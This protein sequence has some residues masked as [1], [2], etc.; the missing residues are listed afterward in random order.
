MA[1][2]VIDG[3]NPLKGLVRLGGAKNASYKLMIASL[4]GQSQSRLLNFSHIE[5]VAITREIIES[6]GGKTCT[7][8]ERTVFIDPSKLD[9]FEI[10]QK[11]GPKSR[12]STMFIPP[13]LHRLGRAVV[14]TPGGDNIGQ[15]PLDRHFD[16]LVAMG[17][18]ISQTSN[19]IEAMVAGRLRGVEYKFSK[20]SHTGT[21]TLIM[22]AVLAE[23]RTV[24]KN[25]GLES[26]IDDLIEM[27]NDMGARIRRRPGRVIEIHGVDRLEGTIHKIIPDRNE[28][29]SYA[30]AALI[31]KGDIIVENANPE[32]LEAFLEKLEEVG[33][34]Y[35]I[36]NYGI[37]FFY[38][39]GMIAT[40]VVTRPHPG[41]MTDWQPL[42]T[43]LATQLQ[44]ESLIHETI[45]PNRFQHV[46]GLKKFGAKINYAKVDV[47]EPD[48]TYNFNYQQEAHD[49]HAVVVSGQT[50]L[51]PASLDVYDL[52]S[53]AT[54]VLAALAANGQSHLS[55]V[56]LI[57][58]GYESFDQRLRS[59][60]AKIKRLD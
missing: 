23:G 10:D 55:K 28:A 33:A 59:M 51:K 12:A 57:D 21:E 25:A 38:Q 9:K 8:G 39:P 15:R 37:R 50:L 6:L 22:A 3:G 26:E 7:A 27:L 24:L 1:K 43:V 47:E 48:K 60:G 32:H 17:A 35:E 4:V 30:C 41:F 56:E 5:D 58:R 40:D 36:G 44:G 52:R 54:F 13:L 11:F 2:F 46:E 19:A 29:V 16:G 20:N 31:T 53:G 45:F 42:W 34:G 18:K 49:K 14:P